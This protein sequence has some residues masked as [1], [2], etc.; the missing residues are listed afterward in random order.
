[1]AWREPTAARSNP[2][3]RFAMETREHRKRH[4]RFCQRVV[5]SML[6]SIVWDS[7]QSQV[8]S[9]AGT[10]FLSDPHIINRLEEYADMSE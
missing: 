9:A 2:Y 5:V 3:C 1:M 4:F 7:V 8:Y 6:A 10:M